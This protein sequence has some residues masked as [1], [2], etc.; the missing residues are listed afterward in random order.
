[1]K[2]LLT[3]G[4]GFLGSYVAEQLC[5]EGH[6]VRALVRP[7]SD[8]RVLQKL[9]ACEFAPGAIEDRASL[10]GAVEGVDAVVHVAGIVKA[11]SP[12]EFYATNTQGTKNLVDAALA[13][14]G[15]KRF[16]YVSSLAAVGPSA[17]GRPVDDKAEPKPVTHYGRSK[18]EAERA[19][20]AAADRMPVTVIRPPLIYG[21][22]DKE[23]L[24]FFTSIKNGVLPVI[25]DRRNTLSVVYGADCA[26]ALVRAV[27]SN[28][29]PS[30]RT[31]F[32]DDGAI[33]TQGELAAEAER[34]MGR[35]A[36]LRFDMPIPVVQVAA[37]AT[38]VWGKLTGTA[39]ML[40]LDKVREL[41]QHHWVCS[42]EGARKELGWA[43]KVGWAQGVVE[44]VKWY[45]AEG[46]L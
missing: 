43:P 13:G 8:K 3:G 23:T 42:G 22:R 34:A 4:S 38:Q 35:R 28:G 39:Q 16:V 36:F 45:R 21:P 40:T 15:I 25:G 30:G 37:A 5:A 41:K 24:A 14:G 20:L 26:A 11:R 9:G 31:Y 17:D 29:A 12:A 19:V 6:T 2:V 7:R 33:Y 18:L 44:A 46:W 10:D 1:M 32:V 27:T